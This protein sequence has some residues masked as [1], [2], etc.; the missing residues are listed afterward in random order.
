MLCSLLF[1]LTMYPMK[2]SE[3]INYMDIQ[4]VGNCYMCQKG[5]LQSYICFWELQGGLE[6]EYNC[7]NLI[8]QLGTLIKEL[9]VT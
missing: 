5:F 7:F 2:L 8:L 4:T 9:N 6:K 1:H 3:R